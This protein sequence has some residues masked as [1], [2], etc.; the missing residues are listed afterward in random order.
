MPT[1]AARTRKTYSCTSS[2][3][4]FIQPSSSVSTMVTAS[5][6]RR[7]NRSRPPRGPRQPELGVAQ[8]FD[9]I[10]QRRR[11]FEIELRRGGAHLLLQPGQIRIELLLVVEALRA[12]QRRRRRHVVALVDA[13]HD[14]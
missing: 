1:I 5:R 10:A 11:L 3:A 4:C 8:A 7:A 14:L 13:R 2:A 6:R 9:L 12:V